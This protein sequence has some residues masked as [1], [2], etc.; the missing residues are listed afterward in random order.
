M[1][2]ACMAP[3]PPGRAG[4]APAK[5]IAPMMAADS[6]IDRLRP[7]RN[8]KNSQIAKPCKTQEISV[9]DKAIMLS[10]LVSVNLI[11]EGHP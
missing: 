11:D 2:A 4:A 6:A 3:M 5:I 9:N 1:T 7:S 10:R 8:K